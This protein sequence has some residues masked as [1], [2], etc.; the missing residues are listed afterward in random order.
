M[1]ETTRE[2]PVNGRHTTDE[3]TELPDLPG[4]RD[5]ADPDDRPTEDHA[6]GYAAEREAA[7]DRLDGGVVDLDEDPF[8]DDLADRLEQRAP[9]LKPNRLTLVLAGGLLIVIGFVGGSLSQKQWGS[10]TSTPTNPFAGAG[11]RTGASAFPGGG[12][13]GAPGGFGGQSSTA[14]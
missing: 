2:K 3:T 14:G 8:D 11:A 12:A 10:S 9:R 5:A 7:L 1:S 4:L 13:S 6:A